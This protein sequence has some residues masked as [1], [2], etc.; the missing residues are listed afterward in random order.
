MPG[1]PAFRDSSRWL[2]LAAGALVLLGVAGGLAYGPAKRWTMVSRARQAAAEAHTAMDQRLFVAT[3]DKIKAALRFA[4]ADPAVLRVAAKFLSMNGQDRAFGYWDQL[5]AGGHATLTDRQEM[6]RLAL[7]LNRLDIAQPGVVDLLRANPTNQQN[8]EFAL[9]LLAAS[10]DLEATEAAALE[11]LKQF[12]GSGPATIIKAQAKLSGTNL[13]H[14]REAIDSLKQ[15]VASQPGAKLAA[16]RVLVSATHLPVPERRPWAEMLASDERAL[17]SDRLRALDVLW[18]AIPESQSEI[19][20]QAQ[21][22]LGAEQTEGDLVEV[23]GWLRRHGLIEIADS[24]LPAAGAK[25][26]EG[27]FLARIEVLADAQQWNE[28][29]KLVE[30]V[31]RQHPPDAVACAKAHLAHRQGRADEVATQ[32]KSAMES[33]GTRWRRLEFLAGYASDLGQV[34]IALEAWNRLLDEPRFAFAAASS[35]L[36]TLPDT[37]FS[38]IERRAVKAL[39]RLQPRDAEIQAQNAYLDLLA[40]EKTDLAAQTFER[41]GGLY[42]DA[43]NLIFGLAFSKFRQNQ[44]EKAL[45]LIEKQPVDWNQAEPHHRAIY[46]AILASNSQF[47]DARLQAEKIAPNK[48]RPL[49]LKLIAELLPNR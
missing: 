31:G 29:A 26:S 24:L 23:A 21:G 2:W 34:G 38:E 6:V 13:D 35:I 39:A 16:L 28:A 22:L 14:S 44:P 27:I 7:D 47:R 48:L 18:S 25:S 46:A 5:I 41:L 33:A 15:V 32:L 10:G 11:V 49:E 1:L 19:A 9:E 42:P 3:S 4:P 17:V 8:Q 12:P 37:T 30:E 45:S 20:K 40:G 43:P 36:K